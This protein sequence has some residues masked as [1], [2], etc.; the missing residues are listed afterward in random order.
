MPA[1]TDNY[2]LQWSKEREDELRARLNAPDL[3][4]NVGPSGFYVGLQG[5]NRYGIGKTIE[6]AVADLRSKQP[7]AESLRVEAQRLLD[8]AAKLGGDTV[9]TD[10]K[11]M[12]DM[13]EAA[14]AFAR[15]A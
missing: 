4:F 3:N 14:K 10:P 7:T 15:A 11:L 13:H 6:L 1:I 2:V 8:E 5:F 9:I 12:S